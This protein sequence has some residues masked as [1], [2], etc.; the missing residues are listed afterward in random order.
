MSLDDESETDT[1]LLNRYS[2]VKKLYKKAEASAK[3]CK[4][5]ANRTQKMMWAGSLNFTLLQI[6]SEID[7]RH[8]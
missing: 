3:R 5:P 7:D 6:E 2:H 8:L 4:N 1:E